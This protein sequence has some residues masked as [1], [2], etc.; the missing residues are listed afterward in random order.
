MTRGHGAAM[1]RLN[2]KGLNTKGLNPKGLNTKGLNP[3]NGWQMTR[4]HGP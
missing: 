1:D 4:G 2:P 3:Q